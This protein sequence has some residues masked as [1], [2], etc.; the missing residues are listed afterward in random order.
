MRLRIGAVDRPRMRAHA[1]KIVRL[2]PS[3]TDVA[4]LMPV[5]F[6]FGKLEGAR[7]LLGDGDTGWHI[8]AGEWMLAHGRVPWQDLFSFT[9]P[10]APWYAWEWLADVMMAWLHQ[11]GGMAA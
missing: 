10:D 5:L 6:L 2:M 3:L 8:R 4:F 11:Q 7:T 1:A 9:R